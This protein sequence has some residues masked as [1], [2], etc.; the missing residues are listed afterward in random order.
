MKKEIIKIDN[1][2][3][4]KEYFKQQIIEHHQSGLDFDF[5]DKDDKE[6]ENNILIGL[7]SEFVNSEKVDYTIDKDG[8]LPLSFTRIKGVEDGIR[9]Y[10]HHHP[11]YPDSVI[12]IICRKQFGD[13]PKKHSR[14]KRLTKKEKLVIVRKNVLL[15]F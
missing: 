7:N 12:E 10:K 14:K 2:I 15:T 1:D 8:K 4:E 9:W 11:Y 3:I 6:T 5:W 13:L